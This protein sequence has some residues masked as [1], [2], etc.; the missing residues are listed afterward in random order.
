MK[1]M[2]LMFLFVVF[3]G[4]SLNL[5]AHIANKEEYKKYS[6]YITNY[7]KNTVELCKVKKDG[8]FAHC[9]ST[10][11]GFQMPYAIALHNNYAYITNDNNSVTVCH[12]EQN[13]KLTRC[14]STGTDLIS[15]FG[16]AIYNNYAFISSYHNSVRVCRIFVDGSLKECRTEGS[17]FKNPFSIAQNN[18]YAYISNY[19]DTVPNNYP[20]S[21]GKNSISSCKISPRGHLTDCQK[22]SGFRLPNGIAFSKGYAYV[23]NFLI[24]EVRKCKVNLNGTLSGCAST[25]EGFHHPNGIAVH[26]GF[27]FVSNYYKNTVRSCKIADNAELVDCKTSESMNGF[28]N[29]VQYNGFKYTVNYYENTVDIF[30]IGKDNLSHKSKESVGGFQGPIGIAFYK[31]NAYVINNN[32]TIRSCKIRLEDGYLSA[33]TL[34]PRENRT[35]GIALN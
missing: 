27:A 30:E 7:L 22:N 21:F 19:N 12:I 16:I 33:C 18:G 35:M 20:I 2:L 31:D 25:G 26:D 32:N 17:G 1:N 9:E 34:R 29:E 8:V 14:V 10:G 11:S 24:N 5:S 15:P 4:M 23:T 28:R 6:A 13:A 3:M